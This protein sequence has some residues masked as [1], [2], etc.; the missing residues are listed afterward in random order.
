MAMIQKIVVAMLLF[1]GSLFATTQMTVDSS[2]SSVG[3]EIR[4]MMIST[5]GGGFNSYEGHLSMDLDSKD[6]TA[7]HATIDTKSIDTANDRRDEHLR[8]PDFFDVEKYPEITFEMTQYR[9]GKMVGDLTIKDV[10]RE[11]ELDTKVTGVITDRGT[12][13]AGIELRGTIE[14]DA[15]GI[16]YNRALEVGGV[17]IGNDVRL[18]INIQAVTD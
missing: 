14:R 4:H 9:A 11:V 5:V 6:I 16:T 12:T 8:D 7:L 17:A 18:I 15:F 10:T 1:T 2:H 13:R 3:F